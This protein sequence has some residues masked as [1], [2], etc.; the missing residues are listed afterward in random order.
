MGYS[1]KKTKQTGKDE[2]MEFL[3]GW[4]VMACAILR[5]LLENKNSGTSMGRD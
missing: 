4:N 3:W 1:R 5:G 2:D